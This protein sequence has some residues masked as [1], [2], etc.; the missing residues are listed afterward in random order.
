MIR[1]KHFLNET[2]SDQETQNGV[3]ES[4]TINVTHITIN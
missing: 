1:I 2:E 3:S 4:I